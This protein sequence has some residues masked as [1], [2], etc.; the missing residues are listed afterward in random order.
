MR[1][2]AF[3]PRRKAALGLGLTWYIFALGVVFYFVRLGQPPFWHWHVA[4]MLGW[5]MGSALA[6]GVVVTELSRVAVRAWGVWSDKRHFQVVLFV[7]GAI[8]MLQT[9]GFALTYHMR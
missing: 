3:T 1:P 4:V 2:T 6:C 9:L 8:F 7:A 5:S